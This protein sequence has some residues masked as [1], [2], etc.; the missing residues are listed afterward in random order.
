MWVARRPPRGGLFAFARIFRAVMTNPRDGHYNLASSEHLILFA[1]I[2]LERDGLCM[3]KSDEYRKNADECRRM[4]G[5]TQ[6]PDDVAAWLRLAYS[7]L[8]M[9]KGESGTETASPP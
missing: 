7:W 8:K 2:G 3:S 1:P 5:Q 4:A 9:L 6:Q